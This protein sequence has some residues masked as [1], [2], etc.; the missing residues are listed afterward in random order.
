MKVAII[1]NG[2]IGRALGGALVASGHEV[3]LTARDESKT[4]RIAAELGARSVA[5]SRVAAAE[6]EVIVLAVPYAA[7]SAVAAEIKDVIG[8][9]VVIDVSNPMGQLSASASA[10]EKLAALLPTARVVKALNTVFAGLL[11]DP[12]AHGQTLDA[13]YATDDPAAAETVANLIRSLGFRPVQVGGLET[14]REMEALASLNIKLQI[15][16][17]GD[18]RSSF[19][20]VGAPAAALEELP[21]AA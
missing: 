1:G 5:T 18:W 16:S 2:N 10:A 12:R 11:A 9:K 20:L 21:S 19:V 14:A 13:L 17:K 7:L 6:A 4:Q 3:T 8:D 15:A